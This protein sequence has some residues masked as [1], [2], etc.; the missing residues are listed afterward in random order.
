M[1]SREHGLKLA[2]ECQA[3]ARVLAPMQDRLEVEVV[4]VPVTPSAP[5]L[6]EMT[7]RINEIRTEYG[8]PKVPVVTVLTA[9]QLSDITSA[10]MS[11]GNTLEHVFANRP[12]PQSAGA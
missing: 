8:L 9:E 3:L 7:N 6:R 2:A 10:L 12:A 4:G 1:I 11:A 5:L